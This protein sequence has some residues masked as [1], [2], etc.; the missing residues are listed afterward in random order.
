M[1]HGCVQ[2]QPQFAARFDAPGNPV[3]L[4]LAGDGTAGLREFSDRL[5]GVLVSTVET[6]F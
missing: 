2:D 4:R 3:M 1:E 6:A 5:L